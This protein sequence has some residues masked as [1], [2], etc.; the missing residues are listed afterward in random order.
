VFFA[1]N[2]SL[3]RH[4]VTKETGKKVHLKL[5]LKAVFKVT[6]VFELKELKLIEPF[7]HTCLLMGRRRWLTGE[8]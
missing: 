7:G 8:A 4:F 2:G 3:G 5:S 6:Q 1:L